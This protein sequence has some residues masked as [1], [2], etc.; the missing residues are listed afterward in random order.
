MSSIVS[1]KS[2][3]SEPTRTR[4]YSSSSPSSPPPSSPPPSSTTKTSNDPSH[5]PPSASPPPPPPLIQQPTVRHPHQQPHHP[6]AAAAGL[7]LLHPGV[8]PLPTLNFTAR[9]VSI[10]P[11]LYEQLLLTQISKVQTDDMTLFLC[12]CDLRT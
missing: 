8:L 11:S 1:N 7:P 5:S 2:E 4:L 6:F 12:Y 3:E 10:S 9:Q